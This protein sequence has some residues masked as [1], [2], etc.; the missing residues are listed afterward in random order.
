[1]ACR[2]TRPVMEARR[3]AQ[4]QPDPARARG[5]ARVAQAAFRKGNPY[6]TLR[7]ELGA[8][9]ADA[10]FADLYPERGQ[11]GLAP[12]RLALVT[13]MQ[14][15]EGLCD[16]QAAEA[17][18]GRI[19]WKYLLGLE[20]TDPGFDAS[21][22]CEFRARLV[23]GGAEERLLDRLLERC[24]RA[25][26]AQGARAAAHR[27]HA[28]AGRRP[29]P[30]P[31]GAGGRDLAGGAERAS[32]RRPGLAA[33]PRA[34]RTGTSA[35]PAGSRT[36]ACRE[37]GPS[38]RPTPA[39]SARTGSALLDRWTGRSARG[40]AMRC[41]RS[42]CCATSGSGTS[43]GRRRGPP[44]AAGA[45]S[46]PAEGGAAGGGEGRVAL[47]H[48]G[49]LPHRGGVSWTGYIVHLSETCE[50]ARSPGHP[51]GRRPRHRA[52]GQVHRRDP[53]RPWRPK[54][55]RRASTWS[56]PPTSSAELTRA[57]PARSTASPWSARG[58]RTR[59]G[60]PG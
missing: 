17:V 5:T 8:I 13:L 3:V 56:T 53:R 22:L 59:A 4:A 60:R 34:R 15:R 27:L 48:R 39:P 36:S 28:R 20:L 14:F 24:A 52:R 38:A 25:R 6:L 16:R 29:R 40:L 45:G 11:P 10:D 46:L 21:V 19:D 35:T 30:Q 51:R 42:R 32:R 44:E 12:W 49:A 33:R 1:M 50:D 2:F 37:A 57:R 26:P 7:D 23:A 43:R 18:R 47:R 31:P 58:A 9:F 54:A 55:W 41:R